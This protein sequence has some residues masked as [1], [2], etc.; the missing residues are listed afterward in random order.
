MKFEH[1]RQNFIPLA[2]GLGNQLFQ[3]SA[4]LAMSNRNEVSLI[5]NMLNPRCD[6]RNNPDI[7]QF[8]LPEEVRRVDLQPLSTFQ[9]KIALF[10]LKLTATRKSIAL[11]EL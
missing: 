5:T 2:G 3:M 7:F 6:T 10:L 4:G 11:K 8:I 9:R 1:E